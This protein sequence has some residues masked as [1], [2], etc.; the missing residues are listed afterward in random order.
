MCA[1]VT[2]RRCSQASPFVR[3]TLR[4]EICSA[5][6]HVRFGS[7]ADMC[8]AL[9]DVR[10][11]PIADIDLLGGYDR[12]CGHYRQPDTGP[13]LTIGAGWYDAVS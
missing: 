2:E 6:A 4:A 9:A 5:Q 11:V 10:F 12:Q 13:F 7:K 1:S 8:G 3:F